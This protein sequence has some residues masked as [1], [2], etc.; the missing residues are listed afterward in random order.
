MKNLINRVANAQM[1]KL[2]LTIFAVAF[3]AALVLIGVVLYQFVP[4]YMKY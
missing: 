1:N 3:I 4:D 2:N